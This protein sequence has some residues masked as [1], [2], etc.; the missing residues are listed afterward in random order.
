M[1]SRVLL[2]FYAVLFLLFLGRI[3][4]TTHMQATEFI[5][6]FHRCI[7]ICVCQCSKKHQ[8]RRRVASEGLAPKQKLGARQSIIYVLKHNTMKTCNFVKKHSSPFI[9]KFHNSNSNKSNFR[10]VPLNSFC[11]QT[12]DRLKVDDLLELLDQK[13]LG[14]VALPSPLWSSDHV[15]LMATFRFKP[16]IFKRD[17]SSSPPNPWQEG[18]SIFQTLVDE[19]SDDSE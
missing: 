5:F 18:E 19:K 9:N 10:K 4:P 17:Y 13:S 11:C 8:G 3:S 6:N 1:T 12:E 2:P 7:Y 15:A 14:G 16:D